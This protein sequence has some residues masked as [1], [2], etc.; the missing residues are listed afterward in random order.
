LDERNKIGAFTISF[1]P[2]NLILDFIALASR[3]DSI[4][5]SFGDQC[6]FLRKT[7]Y[8]E[9]G[10]FPD[11]PL[12]ED[13]YL[14]QKARKLTKVHKLNGPVVSSSRR[15]QKKGVLTQLLLNAWLIVLYLFG[16]QPTELVKRYSN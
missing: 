6:I 15:F 10:G 9:I 2:K 11:W 5:T 12:F 14:F 8:E 7:F 4:L 3:F 1:E 13:V 16:V